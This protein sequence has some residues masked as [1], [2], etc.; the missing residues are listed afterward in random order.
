MFACVQNKQKINAEQLIGQWD[1]IEFVNANSTSKPITNRIIEFNKDGSC[2]FYRRATK[3]SAE[4]TIENNERIFYDYKKIEG[5]KLN[6]N[7]GFWE[8]IDPYSVKI[9]IESVKEKE[10]TKV[11]KTY[12]LFAKNFSEPNLLLANDSTILKLKRKIN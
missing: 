8:I 4:S 10:A 7:S 3:F 12:R 9:K 1:V 6:I 11:H 2:Q 5:E